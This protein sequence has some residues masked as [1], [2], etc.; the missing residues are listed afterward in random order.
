MF[1]C[2]LPTTQVPNMPRTMPV[3]PPIYHPNTTLA[4]RLPNTHTWRVPRVKLAGSH[5]GNLQVP[6]LRNVQVPLLRNVHEAAEIL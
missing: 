1:D 2:R 3:I 5:A 4:R 6:L